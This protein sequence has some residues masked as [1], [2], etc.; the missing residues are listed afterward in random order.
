MVYRHIFFQR[1]QTCSDNSGSF[2][3][4]KNDTFTLTYL[5]HNITCVLTALKNVVHH[6]EQI[7]VPIIL[8]TTKLINLNVIKFIK[9]TC[10]KL[11][12]VLSL[13]TN[14]KLQTICL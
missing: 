12:S 4:R 2:I 6:M 7:S 1:R 14:K 3:L 8:N 9:R 10:I 5:L 11:N 13:N